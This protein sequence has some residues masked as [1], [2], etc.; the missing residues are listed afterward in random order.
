MAITLSDAEGIDFGLN[1]WALGIYHLNRVKLFLPAGKA[2]Q[3][4]DPKNDGAT[5]QRL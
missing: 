2:S 4:R 1:A 5:T 3:Q